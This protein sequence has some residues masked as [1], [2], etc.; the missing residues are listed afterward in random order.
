MGLIEAWVKKVTPA[1]FGE[2]LPYV[3]PSAL[4][5]M[6]VEA[7][8][9]RA[10]GIARNRMAD[11]KRVG[12]AEVLRAQVRDL[13]IRVAE[14]GGPDASR[15]GGEDRIDAAPANERGA[16]AERILELYFRMTCFHGPIF[17]DLRPDRF[18]W[19]AGVL[20]YYP[21]GLFCEPTEEFSARVADLYA[22][23][24]D[25]DPARFERGLTLYAWDCRPKAGYLGKMRELLRAHFGTAERG[26]MRFEISRFRETFHAI[27]VEASRE[28]GKFHPD[29]AFLGAALVGVYLSLEALGVEVRPIDAY[30]RAMRSL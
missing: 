21:D 20:E 15:T 26:A 11:A 18:R 24:Y 16:I 9:S 25:S 2:F 30:R 13:G 29:L 12:A 28:G 3:S 4:K 22:G 10:V 7:V 1:P 27:F 23:F 6:H 19:R 8:L 5:V 14:V 17:L